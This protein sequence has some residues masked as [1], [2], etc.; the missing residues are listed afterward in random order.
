[1]SDHAELLER[2]RRGAELLAFA[3]TGAAGPE[4]DFKPAADQW[5]V[6]QNVCHLA[7]AELVAAIWLRQVI[8]EESPTLHGYDQDAWVDRLDYARRKL[9]HVIETFRR[10]RSDN[11]D[12]VKDMS[13]ET[14]SRSGVHPTLGPS[15]LIDLLRLYSENTEKHIMQIRAARAAFKEAKAK[16]AV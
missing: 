2:F 3:M 7:D 12:L 11:H 5:S 8:A 10:T 9:S 1:M 6:R 13:V 15:T 14:F 16:A 4:L